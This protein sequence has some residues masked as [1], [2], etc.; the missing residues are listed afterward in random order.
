[1]VLVLKR[2]CLQ[3]FFLSNIGQENVL[4]DIVKKKKKR[5]KKNVFWAIKTRSSKSWKIDIFSKELTHGFGPKMAII[6]TFFFLRNIDDENVFYV[7][8]KR[9]NGFLG[10]KN[11]K[12]KK[13]KNWH[14]FIRVNPRFWSKKGYFCNFFF[15]QYRPGKCLI[16]YCKKKEK[17]EK[18]N[19]SLGYKNRK[20]KK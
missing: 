4:Y 6:P 3:L 15:K 11:K 17:K 18:K 7:I 5:K 2:L 9:K 12:F 10:Y 8:L 13:L 19:A 16:W 20:F 1:M 14:F